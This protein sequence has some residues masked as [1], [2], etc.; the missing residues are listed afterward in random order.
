MGNN[1]G[2]TVSINLGADLDQISV[3]GASEVEKLLTLRKLNQAYSEAE[4]LFKRFPTRA[5]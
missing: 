2:Q 3:A 1:G 4:K 5:A